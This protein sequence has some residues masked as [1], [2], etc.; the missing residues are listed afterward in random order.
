MYPMQQTPLGLIPQFGPNG[1]VMRPPMGAIFGGP[2]G[3]MRGQGPPQGFMR[4]E[5]QTNRLNNS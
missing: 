1:G 2:R 4:G 5:T 3:M